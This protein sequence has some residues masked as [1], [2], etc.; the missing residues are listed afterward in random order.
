LLVEI[1]CGKHGPLN[2]DTSA[3]VMQRLYSL[4]IKPD[5]WKLEPQKTARACTGWC[6]LFDLKCFII[7]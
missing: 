3:K 1:I 5:W 4:G 6:R 7:L 2:E